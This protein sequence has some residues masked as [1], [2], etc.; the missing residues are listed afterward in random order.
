MALIKK[1]PD[2]LKDLEK[3]LVA[4]QPGLAVGV[5][6]L[7]LALFIGL[8]TRTA[9]APDRILHLVEK[10][11]AN[12]DSHFVARVGGASI[13]LADGIFPELAVVVNDLSLNS[14]E[15]CWMRPSLQVDQLKLP[16]DLFRF[17]SG[18]IHIHE[19]L[20]SEVSLTLRSDL[21]QCHR[22][23]SSTNGLENPIR[24]F[25]SSVDSGGNS[26]WHG[27]THSRDS[28]DSVQVDRV[29]IHYLPLTFTTFEIRHLEA[30]VR[31]QG[32]RKIDVKGILD[33]NGE[34]LSGDYSSTAFLKLDYEEGRN[35]DFQLTLDGNWREGRY[36]FKTGFNSRE[37]FIKMQVSMDQIPLNQLLPLLRKYHLLA[38]DYNGRQVWLSLKGGFDG[39]VTNLSSLPAKFDYVRVEGNIGEVE[40]K[41]FEV[42]RFDPFLFKP[43]DIEI[44]SLQLDSLMTFLNRPHPNPILGHLGVFHGQAHV[45]DSQNI[46]LKG[47]D[48]GL[49]FVFSSRGIRQVQPISLVSGEA[50]ISKG[51][52]N[53]KIDRVKPAEG[54]FLGDL[55]LEAD[56]DW[57]KVLVRTKVDDLSLGPVVQKLVTDGGGIGSINGDLQ[58]EFDRG[59]MTDIFG[60]MAVTE[61]SV[62]NFN[63]KK[64]KLNF[65]TKNREVMMDIKVQGLNLTRKSSVQSFLAQF[66]EPSV[67]PEVFDNGHAT[68]KMRTKL[69]DD[70]HWENLSMQLGKTTFHSQGG[71]DAQGHLQA[72]MDVFSS[73]KSHKYRI[74]GTRDRPVIDKEK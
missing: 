74:L 47:E 13:S 28:I 11:A 30:N 18:Q 3:E 72:S 68:L 37:Q 8:A 23:I 61:L 4:E 17:L 29:R 46:K 20:A 49:E 27:F 63:I 7:V 54:V 48:T 21:S 52:W 51:K 56:R 16:V 40:A 59:T 50:N 1:V 9:L 36:L 15:V 2:K 60:H 35:S 69:L 5:I 67:V 34:T 31:S 38:T 45:E 42:L 64:S 55:S 43:I 25:A 12:I 70:F 22:K 39:P 24:A 19:I 65:S 32:P 10:A 58:F 6:G 71:W 66:L 62:D 57:T 73:G 26:P 44:K 53:V 41:N 33:L 14:E